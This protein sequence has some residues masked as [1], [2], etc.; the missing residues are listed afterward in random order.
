[1]V[2]ARDVT[3]D[4]VAARARRDLATGDL[5]DVSDDNACARLRERTARRAA[6]TARTPGHE[7]HLPFE[8]AAHV[9]T[10]SWGGCGR[11][12]LCGPVAAT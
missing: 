12:G 8:A 7:R 2:E 11:G 6:E 10:I 5:V 3:E 9:V 1:M 4:E